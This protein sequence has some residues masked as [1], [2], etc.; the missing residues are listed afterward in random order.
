MK[1]IYPNPTQF[2]NLIEILSVINDSEV[3]FKV[4]QNGLS[5]RFEDRAMVC[6]IDFQLKKEGFE[7]FEINGT[8]EKFAIN[9]TIL[10]K[11]LKRAYCDEKLLL[12][13]EKEKL[14]VGLLSRLNRNFKIPLLEYSESQ[15]DLN[16][17]NIK[18][19]EKGL[20][21]KGIIKLVDLNQAIEDCKEINDT[22]TFETNEN[23]LIL[24]CNGDTISDYNLPLEL[25]NTNPNCKSIYPLDYLEKF[26]K[27]AKNVFEYVVFNFNK[28]TPLRLDLISDFIQISYYLAP[29]I[30]ED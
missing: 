15:L 12:E 24:S 20:I 18:E 11:T 27:K 5:A 7:T 6:F 16:D 28:D 17:S 4:N 30:Y 13:L 22:I 23:K 1:L 3:S 29:R 21:A 10:A 19:M 26:V 8:E 25:D 14:K 2:R 9:P